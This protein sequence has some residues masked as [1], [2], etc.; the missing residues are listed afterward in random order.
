VTTYGVSNVPVSVR[1]VPELMYP[2][3]TRGPL[4]A[5]R[6]GEGSD[7]SLG[8]GP[9]TFRELRL[10]ESEVTSTGAIL[11]GCASGGGLAARRH[12]PPATAVQVDVV[13]LDLAGSLM[14]VEVERAAV[15]RDLELA[16]A[17]ADRPEQILVH[18]RAG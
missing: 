18:A 7:I 15:V 11:A 3:R 2:S 12:D 1:A 8:S 4:S 17:P 13:A 9:S 14:L 10:V 6:T 5:F 16:V